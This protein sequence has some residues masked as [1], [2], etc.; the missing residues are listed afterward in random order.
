VEIREEVGEASF[1]AFGHTVGEIAAL[2]AQGYDPGRWI[3]ETP[4]LAPVI[5]SLTRGEVAAAAPGLL[6]P[7]VEA[8]TQGD[9]YF[10]C[11]DFGAYVACQ[12]RVAEAY[13]RPEE[14]TAMSIAN[15]A[16]MGRFSSDRTVRDYA[17]EIWRVEPEP[18]HLESWRPTGRGSG[19]DEGADA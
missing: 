15:V 12:R 2:K 17:R 7:I 16:G 8:L 13:R 3:A 10:H 9:R 18:V 11:A 4:E 6:Q 14:W 1:F 5:E 19:A